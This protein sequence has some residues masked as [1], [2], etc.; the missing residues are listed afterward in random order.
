[1]RVEIKAYGKGK[2]ASI[3][4]AVGEVRLRADS[5]G[6]AELL[7]SLS[8]AVQRADLLAV[9]LELS[10]ALIRKHMSE[11]D[12]KS[13]AGIVE[14]CVARNAASQVFSVGSDAKGSSS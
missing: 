6:D 13:L 2:S 4:K 8:D 11:S 3:A 9:L 7:K 14:R 1:M 5:E 10:D 12:K